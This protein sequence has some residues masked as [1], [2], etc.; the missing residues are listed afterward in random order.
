MNFQENQ[1]YHIY[2]QGND[3]GAIF[4]QEKNYL[5]FLTKMRKILTP[6]LDFLAYCLM[7][8]H[9][10]WLIIPK[11]EGC[12]FSKAIKPVKPIEESGKGKASEVMTLSHHL[13]TTTDMQIGRAHV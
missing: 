1:I 2:N 5:F 4:F 10:H 12:K 11:P 6:Y 8:N 9:F 3:K 7:P 13:T